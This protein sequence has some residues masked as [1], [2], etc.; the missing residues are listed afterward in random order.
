MCEQFVRFGRA[1]LCVFAIAQHHLQ[2]EKITQAFDAVQ[3]HAGA[4]NGGTAFVV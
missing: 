3:M 2:F 1:V 4:A